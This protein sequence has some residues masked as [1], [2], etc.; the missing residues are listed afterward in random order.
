MR[1]ARRLAA[2]LA[3]LATL[4][5][6]AAPGHAGR[7][8]TRAEEWRTRALAA[9][10]QYEQQPDPG[11]W[12]AITYGN[13][14]MAVG[15]L[16]G[17][18]DP[19]VQTIYNKLLAIRNPD[20]GWGINQARD[21][22]AD[23]SVNP[24]DTTYTV[25][26]ASH[27]GPALLAGYKAGVL[28]KEPVQTIV[29]LLMTTPRIDWPEGR[30]IAYSRAPADASNNGYCVHN[31]NA[32]A[33][34]FLDKAND[35]GVGKS[36]LN[37]MVLEITRREVY[38]FNSS[39]L[40]WTYRDAAGSQDADHNSFHAEMMYGLALPIGREVAYH[41]MTTVYTDNANAPIAGI[42][43]VA[44]PMAT[45]T[46]S[47]DTTLWCVLGDNWLDDWDAWTY[48]PGADAQ[49]YAGAAMLAAQNAAACD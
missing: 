31:V 42:R 45:G 26:I 11:T 3:V 22:F 40:W 36:G 33:A 32:A 24:A 37:K 16:R 13:A 12:G 4:A 1:M 8:L 35:A 49:R 39:L 25:T 29:N 6:V 41:H 48:R 18:D 9:L 34:W 44:L 30:C 43:L 20:G 5:A 17:W 10:A 14:L 27:V 7:R 23:G 47:G 2:V 46:R 21:Q 28:P 15:L 38:R 19:A